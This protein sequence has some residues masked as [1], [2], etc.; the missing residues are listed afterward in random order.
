MERRSFFSAS[1]DQEDIERKARSTQEIDRWFAAVALAQIHEPW[2]FE[3]L[4]ALKADND[5]STRVAAINAL[6][7]FPIE[8]FDASLDVSREDSDFIPG[9]WKIR[10]LP[11]YD[12]SCRDLFLAAI[13]DIVGTEGSVTGGRIQTR[14]TGATAINSGKKVSKGRLKTLLDELIKSNVLT[15]ADSHLDSDDIDLWIVHAPGTPEFVV[16]GRDGRDITE[17]PVNEAKAVLLDNRATRR[18]P[19]N[20]DAGFRVLMEQYGIKPNEFFL[21]GEAME[22]QWQTLFLISD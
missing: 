2:A 5:E 3:L 21:V 16:R 1:I 17:I 13:V 4:K 20:R 8:F 10:P 7:S 22:H 9:I 12:S 6:R 19:A 15:R 11:T 14:L 18:N